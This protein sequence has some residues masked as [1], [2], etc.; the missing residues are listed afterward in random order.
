MNEYQ[1]IYCELYFDNKKPKTKSGKII[2]NVLGQLENYIT[3]YLPSG[4]KDFKITT[5]DIENNMPNGIISV[6]I[7]S[8][9][10]ELWL[11]RGYKMTTKGIK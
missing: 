6:R 8:S 5:N 7:L 11:S 9:N 1:K 2:F 4:P 3:V 10:L